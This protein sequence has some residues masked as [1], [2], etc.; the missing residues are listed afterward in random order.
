MNLDQAKCL[1]EEI[2]DLCYEIDNTR[3]IEVIESI[4]LDAV[5]SNTISRILIFLEELQ[6][7]LLE[8]DLTEEEQ[9]TASE[10]QEKIELMSE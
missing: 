7:V 2:A 1:F 9:E 5:K 6:V 4:Y 3:V 10:I 8:E